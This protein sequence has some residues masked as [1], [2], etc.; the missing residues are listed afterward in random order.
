MKIVSLLLG[1][2]KYLTKSD[3]NK[4][5]KERQREYTS[6]DRIQIYIFTWKAPKI[7]PKSVGSFP[8]DVDLIVANVQD[9]SETIDA[10]VDK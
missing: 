7:A 8:K 4:L 5:L 9:L 10:S 6:V 2:D 3:A 1:N